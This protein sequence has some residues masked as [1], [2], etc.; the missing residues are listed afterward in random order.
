MSDSSLRTLRLRVSNFYAE[1]PDSISG[2]SRLMLGVS[3]HL[4]V[5][6]AGLRGAEEQ[7][8]RWLTHTGK[9]VSPAGRLDRANAS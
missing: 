8:A 5:S 1:F 4:H 7:E 6:P 9:D 3:E 2:G